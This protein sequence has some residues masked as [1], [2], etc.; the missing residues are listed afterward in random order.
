MKTKEQIDQRIEEL[1]KWMAGRDA[2]WA[3]YSNVSIRV[4]NWLGRAEEE[5]LMTE[6]N[7]EGAFLEKCSKYLF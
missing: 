1:N 4:N 2:L 3:Q 5:R 6:Y 7:E